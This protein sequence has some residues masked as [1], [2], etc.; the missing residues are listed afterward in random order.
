MICGDPELRRLGAERQEAFN[1]AM[2]R[3]DLVQ[4]KELLADQTGWVRSYAT[5]CGV[6]PN[7]PPPNPVPAAVKQCFEQAG[8]ARIAYLRAYGAPPAA[9]P[10]S[11]TS[12]VSGSAAAQ[13]RTWWMIDSKKRCYQPYK[14]FGGAL[15]AGNGLSLTYSPN[16]FKK[17]AAKSG[18]QIENEKVLRDNNTGEIVYTEIDTVNR[19]TKGKWVWF[20]NKTNCEQWRPHFEK[21]WATEQTKE[22]RAEITKLKTTQIWYIIDTTENTCRTVFMEDVSGVNY[23]TLSPEF[24]METVMSSGWRIVNRKLYP[25]VG[26]EVIVV[27][28]GR[29][30]MKIELYVKQNDCAVAAMFSKNQ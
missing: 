24:G 30:P 26:M 19:G 17:S 3:L 16:D 25:R 7:R 23:L 28:P 1:E 11:T 14:A 4:Q 27:P 12:V 9:R 29:S 21:W 13:A 22:N 2:A 18:F 6:P 20:S 8:R 10:L 5:A 15:G